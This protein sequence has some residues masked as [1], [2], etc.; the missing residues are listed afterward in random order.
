MMTQRYADPRAHERMDSGACPECGEKAEQH[1]DDGR[2]W[3]PRKCDLKP[4]GV[5]DR[6]EQYRQDLWEAH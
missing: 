1:L 4:Q 3:I 5:I 6:I 2:F